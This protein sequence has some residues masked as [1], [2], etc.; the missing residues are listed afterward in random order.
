[1]D[2]TESGI[3]PAKNVWEAISAGESTIRVG[4]VE[5]PSRAYVAA[6]GFKGTTSRRRPG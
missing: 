1:M 6:F 4:N 5:I 2:Q 3:D